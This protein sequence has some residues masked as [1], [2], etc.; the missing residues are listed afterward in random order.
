M[1]SGQRE[2]TREAIE[3]LCESPVDERNLRA[4]LLDRIRKVLPF[5]AYV[6]L[7]TDP[8]TT[9]GCAPLAEVP[10]LP[11]LPMLIKRKYLTTVNRWTELR[12]SNDP[13]GL[14]QLGTSGQPTRS[15]LWREMLRDIGITD[16][17]S[18]VFADRYGCWG[19]L[20]LWRRE[21]PFTAAD[22]DWL[23]VLS[24]TITRALRR[25]QAAA[26]ADS[27]P[28]TA[29]PAGPAVLILDDQLRIVSR[30]AAATDWLRSLLPTP[31][32]MSPIPAVAYNVAAQ[33]LATEA[34]VD[35]HPPSVRSRVA[36]QTWVTLRASRLQ[37]DSDHDSSTASA[38]PADRPSGGGPHR[39][40]LRNGAGLVAVSIEETTAGPRL[41]L[42]ARSFG[43]SDREQ[44]VLLLL[45]RAAETR[46]IA[47]QLAITEYTVQ[48]HLKSI[49][50]KTAL[51]SRNAL[52]LTAI[53]PHRGGA[54]AGPGA[55]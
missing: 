39:E 27:A 22:A 12:R 34:G 2:R 19:F 14:L 37:V 6:W 3:R 16:I 51:S 50:H 13:V 47:L 5:D 15:L 4:Q 41:D 24:A 48:D 52:L 53:G 1:V 44:Q 9:V 18:V 11:Q 38:G 33:L 29:P 46:D 55:P 28:A 7:L 31:Q 23:A 45:S 25:R 21:H 35:Q 43:L 26:F 10:C 32:G 36:G 54:S 8:A 42:F 49:F 30:T 40:A 20:D 17:A